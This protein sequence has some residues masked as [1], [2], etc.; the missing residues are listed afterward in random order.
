MWSIGIFS[1]HDYFSY[2][3][4]GATAKYKPPLNECN[5]NK[6]ERE[7]AISE[8]KYC[9]MNSIYISQKCPKG[10]ILQQMYLL[11]V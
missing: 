7:I 6:K 1:D 11:T 4:M 5:N 10:N 2:H 3:L 8:I 9:K